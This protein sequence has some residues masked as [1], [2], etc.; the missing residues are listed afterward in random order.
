MVSLLVS[1]WL[2][3]AQTP[4]VKVEPTEEVAVFRS[5]VSNVRIDVQVLKD[6]ELV[7]G[8][9]A[10]DFEIYDENLP[11]KIVYFGREA[12]PLQLVLLLDVSG[13]MRKYLEQ[14]AEVARQSL[15]FLRHKD[16]V[17]VMV[18]ARNSKVRLGFTPDLD[19][20]AR[21]IRSAIGDE[22]LGSG[23]AINDALTDVAKYIDTAAEETGRRAVLI[24]SDNL[25]LNYKNSDE[26]VVRAL[27]SANTVVNGLIVGKG[28]KPEVRPGVTY[29][30]PDFTPPDIFQIASDTGGEAVKAEQAGSAFLRMI[31]RIRTRYS[32]HYNKPATA[33][34]G[35]RQVRV[36][37]TPDAK[38]RYPGA[39]VRARRG[40]FVSEPSN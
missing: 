16:K 40:Y 3:S 26:Q 36:E 4:Q 5:G 12:E 39:V 7:T 6:N 10:A 17:A 19:G 11:Q 1:L 24:L 21:E 9:T 34:R 18:F 14:V 29:L 38:L 2:A 35:F 20:V 13:S 32:I 28:Q 25:G 23:T 30:N 8:L 37:L 33:T 27:N 15:R 22:T 31:E